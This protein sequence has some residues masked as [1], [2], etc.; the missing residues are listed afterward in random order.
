MERTE[1]YPFSETDQAHLQFALVMALYKGKWLFVKH[2]LRDTLE[3]P[4]GRREPDE[5]ILRTAHRELFEETGAV[6]YQLAP[7]S[8]YS[9]TT[10]TAKSHGLLC[11]A[12]IDELGPLPASEIE[13]V[14]S[15]K[16]PPKE[17]TYCNIPVLFAKAVKN[18][19]LIEKFS[20]YQH[21]IFDWNGTLLDDTQICVEVI[22]DLLAEHGLPRVSAENYRSIFGFPVSDY[23]KKLGFD[24]SRTPFQ[25]VGDQ[26]MARYRQRLHE[27]QLFEGVSVMLEIL[28]QRQLHLSILSA[29][30]QV[31]LDEATEAH[32]IHRYLN[33]IFGTGDHYA[34]SKLQRGRELLQQMNIPGSKTL[35]VGD[36]DHDLDVGKALGL[37]VL[38]VADGHQ[39]YER[40]ISQHPNTIK[41][42][43]QS[44]VP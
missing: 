10:A 22:S 18:T 32:G 4:G 7:I 42:R 39:H 13:R 37:E 33:H 41:S 26:F 9:V 6:R 34:S 40:L 28:K 30:S 27:A 44:Q 17:M 5:N 36:T 12:S 14:V 2:R 11:F 31:H 19:G 25:L 23:Y 16:E 21:V 15:L 29:A 3:I 35:L 24:F 38:L 20:D 1:F 8:S 43:F